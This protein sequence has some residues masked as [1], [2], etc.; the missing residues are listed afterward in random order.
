MRKIIVK[1]VSLFM[2]ITLAILSSV[3][4]VQSYETYFYNGL[5]NYDNIS[6]MR[7]D[8]QIYLIGTSGNSVVLEAVYPN[9]YNI[10]LSLEQDVHMYTLCSDMLILVSFLNDND[11]TKITLYDITNDTFNSFIVSSDSRYMLSHFAYADGFVYIAT[12]DGEVSC[13]SKYGKHYKD[14]SLNTSLCSLTTDFEGNVYAMTNSGMYNITKD[15]YTKILNTRFST[16]GCFVSNDIFV[17]ETGNFYNLNQNGKLLEFYCDSIYPC[18]GVHSKH[19]ITFNQNKIYA[20]NSNTGQKVLY[21]SLNDDVQQLYSIGSEIVALTYSEGAP[22]ISFIGFDELKN[23]PT[24]SLQKNNRNDLNDEVINFI[25]SDVYSVDFDDMK[26]THIPHNTTV[27]QFKKNMEYDGYKVEFYRYEKDTV[28]KSGNVGTA[29]QAIF[30][31]NNERYV[32]ELSVIGDL[33]GEG[34]VNSRDKNQIF[35]QVVGRIEMTGVFLDSADLDESNEIDVIDIVLLLRM[36]KA[37]Q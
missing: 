19:L 23:I 31:N 15:S 17:D 32:F 9:E 7:N 36:I 13:Y 8:K 4:C 21:C 11:N 30:Y 5:S 28:L 26:I 35:G 29:T 6:L 27:A 3:I 1:T 37:Q 18:G 12:P 33:T 10:S 34:N 16:R 22:S 25:S 20:I 14:F 2:V 24:K